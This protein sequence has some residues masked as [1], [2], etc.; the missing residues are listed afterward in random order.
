VEH[1]YAITEMA[2][3]SP[4]ADPLIVGGGRIDE[5]KNVKNS[6]AIDRWVA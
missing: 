5:Q 1:E 6:F 2:P 3:G 4:E